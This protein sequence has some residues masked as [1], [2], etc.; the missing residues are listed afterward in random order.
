MQRCPHFTTM[1]HRPQWRRPDVRLRLRERVLGH[2]LWSRRQNLLR[3]FG[4][5]HEINPPESESTSESRVTLKSSVVCFSLLC[6]AERCMMGESAGVFANICERICSSETQYLFCVNSRPRWIVLS[7]INTSEGEAV[8]MFLKKLLKRLLCCINGTRTHRLK[9]HKFSLPVSRRTWWCHLGWGWSE[10][11][12]WRCMMGN[13]A[14]SVFEA[15]FVNWGNLDLC[16][17]DYHHSLFWFVSRE[18]WRRNTNLL[19]CSF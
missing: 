3:D 2:V 16:S 7:L 8:W 17:C 10:R 14:S 4:W 5:A 1:G 15:W 9:G 19:F 12:C 6:Q 13:V 18:S 11:Y